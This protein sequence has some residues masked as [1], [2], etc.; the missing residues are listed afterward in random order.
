MSSRDA[1]QEKEEGS[2]AGPARAAVALCACWRMCY[3]HLCLLNRHSS[4]LGVG[5]RVLWPRSCRD[6]GLVPHQS[7]WRRC[8]TACWSG[9]VRRSTV[10]RSHWRGSR[11]G[12]AG[13]AMRSSAPVSFAGYT[14]CSSWRSQR[15]SVEGRM[16]QHVPC[17]VGSI[18]SSLA[19]VAEQETG[20]E[21]RGRGI[22]TV[23]VG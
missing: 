1:S 9:S 11:P 23:Y 5:V 10:W 17:R 8:S 2:S 20:V 14:N 6:D 12:A 7:R 21:C 18:M 13:T 16:A 15:L 4:S 3:P 22:T 19:A